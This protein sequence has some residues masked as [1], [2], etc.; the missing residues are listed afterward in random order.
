MLFVAYSP[1]EA[2][3]ALAA[4]VFDKAEEGRPL[5]APLARDLILAVLNPGGGEEE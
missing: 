2:P 5:A 1:R 3:A 4:V